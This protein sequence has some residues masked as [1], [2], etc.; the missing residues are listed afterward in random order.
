MADNYDATGAVH[1][2]QILETEQNCYTAC[3]F[4][5]LLYFSSNN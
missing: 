1:S 3:T 2:D 5:N 4:S